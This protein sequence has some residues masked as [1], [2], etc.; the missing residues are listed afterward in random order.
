M[1]KKEILE[2]LTAVLEDVFSQK[3]LVLE[4]DT[5]V[6][7]LDSWDSLKN[8]QMIAGMEEE[9]DIQFKFS[10]LSKLI[11]VGDIITIIESKFE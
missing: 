9:F 5:N 11:K 1:G 6:I 3:N 2:R 10:E 8:M 4:E 7:E